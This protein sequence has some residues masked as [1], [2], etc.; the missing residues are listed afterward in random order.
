MDLNQFPLVQFSDG[1]KHRIVPEDVLNALIIK[2]VADE[3]TEGL[4]GRIRILRVVK[5]L[6]QSELA[7]KVGITQARLSRMEAG[8]A[9]I[10]AEIKS[11]LILELS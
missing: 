6:S 11:K 7:E 9:E 5:G 2:T 1:T 3:N 8:T 4:P 10:P